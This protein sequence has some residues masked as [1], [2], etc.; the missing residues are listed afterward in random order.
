MICPGNGPSAQFPA[1][2]SQ[3]WLRWSPA[4]PGTAPHA[5]P[6]PATQHQQAA[7]WFPAV[8]GPNGPQPQHD[9]APHQQGVLVG[10]AGGLILYFLSVDCFLTWDLAVF[11]AADGHGPKTLWQRDGCETWNPT[12]QRQEHHAHIQPL[13]VPFLDARMLTHALCVKVF[14][15]GEDLTLLP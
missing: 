7:P 10:G 14:C 12:R 2:P 1:V 5:P 11:L 15:N 6:G 8:Q 4:P 9:A 13:Q 3:L